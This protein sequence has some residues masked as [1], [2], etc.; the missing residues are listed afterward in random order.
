MPCYRC[1]R[2]QTDPVRGAPSWGRGV[3]RERQVLIC[4]AC[5]AL[6]PTW[7]EALD[8]CDSCGSTRLSIVMGSKVCRQCWA[9]RPVKR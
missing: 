6:D 7:H 2:P 4:P 1:G 9:D 5:Q 8:R 3:L